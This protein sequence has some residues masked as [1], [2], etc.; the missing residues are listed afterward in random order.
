MIVHRK[1]E[2]WKNSYNKGRRS[3]LTFM[4]KKKH[5]ISRF[6]SSLKYFS[7]IQNII[8]YALKC[9]TRFDWNNEKSV[10]LQII[11]T[12]EKSFHF[13]S[14]HWKV[15]IVTKYLQ[16]DSPF[17]VRHMFL[18]NDHQSFKGYIGSIQQWQWDS[19]LQSPEMIN[20]IEDTLNI[21]SEHLKF[22]IWNK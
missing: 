4:E 21:Q 12:A 22:L 13:S 5:K 2:T 8:T 3:S 17:S 18:A 1:D 14:D 20:H 15:I 10:S 16:D 11:T 7:F 19:I 6:P 9:P